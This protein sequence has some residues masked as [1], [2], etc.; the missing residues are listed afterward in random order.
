A[1][2]VPVVLGCGGDPTRNDVRRPLDRA[3]PAVRPVRER[4]HRPENLEGVGRLRACHAGGS[5][6][7]SVSLLFRRKDA[8]WKTRSR[9]TMAVVLECRVPC[10]T[11]APGLDFK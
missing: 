9:L 3:L 10:L 4:V 2:C 11:C 1:Q 6:V 7:P 5:I 8:T